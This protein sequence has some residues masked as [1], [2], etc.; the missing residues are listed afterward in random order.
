[1][2]ALIVLIAPLPDKQPTYLCWFASAKVVIIFNS[3][4]FFLKNANK[5]INIIL[6]ITFW[7]NVWKF[8]KLVYFTKQYMRVCVCVLSLNPLNKKQHNKNKGYYCSLLHY[9]KSI[10][11]DLTMKLNIL[12][13]KQ[14]KVAKNHLK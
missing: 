6:L 14:K 2:I 4:N 5:V 1:L 11:D 3:A 8:Q 7:K 10:L 9:F 12:P 13:T